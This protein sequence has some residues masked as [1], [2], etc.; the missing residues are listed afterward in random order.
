MT[1]LINALIESAPA[2]DRATVDELLGKL[3]AN[4]TKLALTIARILE[5]VD[6]DLVDAGIALPALAEAI[7]ALLD[8]NANAA[9]KAAAEYRIA[10]LEPRPDAGR[11]GAVFVVPD[12]PLSSLSRGRPPRT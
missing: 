5:F 12:V 1:E 10:T 11:G 3:R 4:G 9:S 2:R 7:D 6:E 8:A